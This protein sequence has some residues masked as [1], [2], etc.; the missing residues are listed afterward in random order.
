MC[1]KHPHLPGKDNYE[2]TLEVKL[3]E[4]LGKQLKFDKEGDLQFVDIGF[5]IDKQGSPS[6][7]FL[8]YFSDA[9]QKSNQ[10]FQTEL[11]HTGVDLLKQYKHWETGEVREQK[12]ITENNV[13][14][15][16]YP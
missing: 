12:V 10:K 8:N 3:N 13:R 11:F 5:Y 15:Y 2:T 7:Y 4:N 6:G 1:D 14:I 16:F 9:N